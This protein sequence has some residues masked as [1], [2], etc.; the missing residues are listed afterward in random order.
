M[1]I[2]QIRNLSHGYT[3]GGLFSK[4]HRIQVL[5]ELSLTLND[6]QSLGLLGAS[7]SG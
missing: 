5:K 3:A 2:F 6:G 7:G 4:R 1:S